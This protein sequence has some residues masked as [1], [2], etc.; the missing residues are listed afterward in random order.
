VALEFSAAADERGDYVEFAV[1]ALE[2]WNMV[3]MKRRP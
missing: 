2:Y 3:F 1:P